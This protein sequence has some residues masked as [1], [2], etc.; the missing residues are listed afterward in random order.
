MGTV[1]GNMCNA[2]DAIKSAI[3]AGVNNA[4]TVQGLTHTHYTKDHVTSL[5]VSICNSLTRRLDAQATRRLSA[6]TVNFGL[7]TSSATAAS[8]LATAIGAQGTAFA[9]AFTSTVQAQAPGLTVTGVSAAAIA[10]TTTTTTLGGSADVA[11][12]KTSSAV[13]LLT[14]AISMIQGM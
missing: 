10:G 4:S 3:A 5:I 6:A 7:T 1:T 2:S 14:L 11:S 13:A 8:A 9:S 12:E